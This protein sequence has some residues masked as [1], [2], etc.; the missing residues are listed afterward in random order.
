[1]NP[2][3]KKEDILEPQSL[4]DKNKADVA[5]SRQLSQDEILNRIDAIIHELETLRKIVE[6]KR[7]ETPRTNLADQLFG[8]LGKG[9]WEEYDTDV[10][11]RRFEK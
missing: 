4:Q 3:G 1:M 6:T 7:I 5:A 2:N 8:S 9:T 11:W 10:D